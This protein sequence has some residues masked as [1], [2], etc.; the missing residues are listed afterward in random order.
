VK[1]C[2]QCGHQLG[3]GRV[4]TNCGAPVAARPD[5]LSD[6]WQDSTAER[7]PRPTATAAPPP[8]A[9]APP[10]VP[11]VAVE[12]PPPPRFPLFADEL[13]Q[14]APPPAAPAAPAAPAVE[15]P[16]GA[17][18]DEDE[19]WDDEADWEE[20]W[21]DE[22]RPRIFWVLTAVAVLAVLVVGG[23]FLGQQ[24]GGDDAT[25]EDPTAGDGSSVT[26][27]ERVD[28]TADA[29]AQAPSTAPPGED[30]EGQPTSYDPSNMLDGVPETTWR[31]EGDASGEKLVFTFPEKVR[32]TEVGLINGY[33]K[34]SR[35]GGKVLDWYDGHRRI[36]QVTW[37]FADGRTVR[38]DLSESRELQTI[39]VEPIEVRRVVLKIV[40]TS[41]PGDGAAARDMTAISDV[42]LAGT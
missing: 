20:D 21:D 24:L 42:L 14:V 35:D 31:T 38:Q 32:I 11:P 5:P 22:G 13:P 15:E 25:A 12:P 9:D 3:L 10:R 19:D 2:T 36:Q 7:T 1:H 16:A 28:H 6:D 17:W 34:Q 18:T 8:V 30:V 33:A 4:C 39:E 37:I 23:W 26:G 27:T 40:A 29:S 41:E